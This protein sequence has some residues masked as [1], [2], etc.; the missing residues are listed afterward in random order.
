MKGLLALAVVVLLFIGLSLAVGLSLWQEPASCTDHD[1]AC[2][3]G[4]PTSTEQTKP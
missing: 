1:G 3:K 2:G 4:P